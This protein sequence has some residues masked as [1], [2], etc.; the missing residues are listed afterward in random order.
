MPGTGKIGVVV[1]K[2]VKGAVKRNRVKRKLR[3]FANRN[4]LRKTP[5]DVILMAYGETFNVEEKVKF[6]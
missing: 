3:E 6:G 1:G 4:V 5:K 2:G